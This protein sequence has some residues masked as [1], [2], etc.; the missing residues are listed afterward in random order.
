MK[1]LFSKLLFFL[2]IIFLLF[3]FPLLAQE[4][5]NNPI[6]DNKELLTNGTLFA[7]IGTLFVYVRNWFVRIENIITEGTK[8]YTEMK[9]DMEEVKKGIKK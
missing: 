5:S 7:G 6:A 8:L 4:V 2:T 1:K 9:S 3:C